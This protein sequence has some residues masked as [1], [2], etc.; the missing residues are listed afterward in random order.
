[1][2]DITSIAKAYDAGVE[3]EYNRLV[4]NPLREA[5]Y[6]LIT[7]LMEQYIQANATVIDIGAGPGRYA[8]Y[9]LKKNCKVGLVDL[10]AKSLDAFNKRIT[11]DL[12]NNVLF[13]KVS[14]A[15]DLSFI[16]D[17][18]ADAVLLMGPLYHLTDCQERTQAISECYRILNTGGVLFAVYMS[19][20]PKLHTHHEGET[21]EIC[22]SD[23]VKQLLKDGITTIKFQGY[24]VPQYRCWP[25]VAKGLIENNGFGTMRIRNIEGIGSSLSEKELNNMT[26]QQSKLNLF[27]SLRQTCEDENLLGFTHQ[28]LYV[29]RK[30]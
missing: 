20:F 18:S 22:C 8:E 19:L 28:F 3:E 6:L 7:E 16:K 14:C 9:L 12:K 13:T 24:T 15:T 5:E 10:S 25:A 4:S 26:D 1:M 29:G 27:H 23:Y 2:T 11:D 21:H 30:N 17:N